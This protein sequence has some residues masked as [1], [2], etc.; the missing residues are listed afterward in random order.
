[1]LYCLESKKNG[2]GR[3]TIPAPY[4]KIS[5][6]HSDTLLCHRSTVRCPYI[7]L[8]KDTHY[9]GND[10]SSHLIRLYGAASRA[11]DPDGAP[12]GGAALVLRRLWLY[13]A[14]HAHH[15]SERCAARQ[16]RRRDRKA[17]LPFLQG[18]QRPVPSLR[19]DGASGE[20]RCPALCRPR[21]PVPPFPDRKGL[22]RRARAARPLPRVLSGRYRRHRRRRAR[23]HERCRDPRHHLYR[24]LPPRPVPFPDPHQQP[25][26]LKR[27][28]RDAGP[29]RQVRR[30][31]AHRRQDRKDRP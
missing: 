17:D 11:A 13:P 31:H 3:L 22:S 16:G 5:V 23:H 2:R 6:N 10:Q 12:Y 26:H 7:L 24:L 9:H 28:L 27:L 21:F 30:Y 29:F 1:M 8:G 19:P 18:R 4:R 14:R 15:R 25:P 20:I